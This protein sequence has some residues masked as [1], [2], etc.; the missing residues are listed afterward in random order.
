MRYVLGVDAAWSVNHPSGVALLSYTAE[1]RPK[2]VRAGRSYE[3]F[4][5]GQIDWPSKPG[6]S[7]PNFY[8]LLK[9]CPPVSVIALDIPLA[10]FLIQGRR[11][12]DQALSKRYAKYKA[13]VYSPTKDCP[14]PLAKAIFEQISAMGY[15]W[16]LEYTDERAFF[17]VYPHASIIEL[18]NYQ[19]RFP[20]KV[21]KKNKYWPNASQTERNQNILTNLNTLRDNLNTIVDLTELIPNL[22][23]ERPYPLTYLKGYEDLLDAVVCAVTGYYY[24]QGRCKPF[25]DQQGVAWVP[26]R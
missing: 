13:A 20:Y 2:L 11:E 25:G 19:E 9:G 15:T 23:Q 16:A 26:R 18:F 22:E 17:E 4:Q 3:E 24:L 10:P 6:G 5:Q 8:E 21:S 1:G 14:G 7:P 12:V